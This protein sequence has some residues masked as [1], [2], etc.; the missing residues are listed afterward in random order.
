MS[1][2]NKGD[3]QKGATFLGQLGQVFNDHEVVRK[4]VSGDDASELI[5][6]EA[7]KDYQLVVLGATQGKTSA[8]NLFTPLVDTLIRLAPSP[9]IMVH[10]REVPPDWRPRHILIP[11]NGS[12][13]ARRA[14]EVGI[15]LAAEGDEELLFVRVVESGGDSY[16]DAKGNLLERQMFASRLMVDELE[17]LGEAFGVR[18]FG[19]VKLGREPETLILEMARQKSSD[20]IILG[21]SVH[22]GSDR[23]Y[24]GPRVERILSNAP[25]PVI[26]VN[27]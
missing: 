5:L 16:L 26:V 4:V 27:S 13:A 8:Q 11:T 15:A 19:E 24:L 3:E 23:L 12:V 14:A 9:T 2:V 20:L 7:Q 1:V 18:T 25:C 21:V 10:G 22:A 6:N 17:K